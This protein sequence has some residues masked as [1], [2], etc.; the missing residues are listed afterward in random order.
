MT[1]G[2]EIWGFEMLDSVERFH[3]SFFKSVLN[4]SK[5][6]AN[7]IIYGETG[8]TKV[9][10]IVYTRML[11]FWHRLRTGSSNKISHILFKFAKKQADEN[12][13]DHKWGNK[14]KEVQS[15]PI[16]RGCHV[17]CKTFLNRVFNPL[18]IGFDQN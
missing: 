4:I 2:C 10:S 11:S 8:I 9:E 18:P 15:R 6:T 16:V 13:F 7:S 12:T 17:C 14:I 1:Y 5:Y 3:R